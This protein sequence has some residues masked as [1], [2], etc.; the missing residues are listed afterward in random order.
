MGKLVLT[1]LSTVAVLTLLAEGLAGG[2]LWSQGRLNPDAIREIRVI[3]S[4]VEQVSGS[5][6]GKTEAPP[7]SIEDVIQTR[8]I[9]ILHLNDREREQEVLRG[10]V[11]DSRVTV[12]TEQK[13][14]VAKREQFE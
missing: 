4:D 1:A 8:A 3:L 2:L 13:A 5:A 9:R 14:L 11:A 6:G 10:L 7:A 12:V